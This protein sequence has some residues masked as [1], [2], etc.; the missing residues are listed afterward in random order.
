MG[1]VMPRPKSVSFSFPSCQLMSLLLSYTLSESTLVK[2]LRTGPVNYQPAAP[3][4]LA[5][6][7]NKGTAWS[8]R[9]PERSRLPFTSQMGCHP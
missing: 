8:A 6:P 1:S 9:Q 3:S 5:Q 7:P 2:R 4:C